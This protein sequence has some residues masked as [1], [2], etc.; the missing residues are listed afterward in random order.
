VHSLSPSRRAA[1][2]TVNNRSL[3]VFMATLHK[4]ELTFPP[5]L[6]IVYDVALFIFKRNCI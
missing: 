6:H 2:A 5:T 1:S 3:T 4:N